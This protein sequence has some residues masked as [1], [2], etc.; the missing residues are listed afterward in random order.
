M[1]GL[2]FRP[3]SEKDLPFLHA[4][5]GTTRA[6]ELAMVPWSDQQKVEFIDMQFKAQ[7]A[8]YQEHFADA[9]F[10]I[11]VKASQDIGRLY[12][13]KRQTEFRIIDIALMPEQQNMGLGRALLED[14]ID[15]AKQVNLPVTIHVEKN[16]PAMRLYLR[17][18]FET[19]EDQGVYDL[20]RWHA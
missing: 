19:V 13:D 8:Y 7:H 15:Q 12:L 9:D 16:N 3:I 1:H 17:L 14:V 5:Y 20:M 11:I 6:A 4:L 10:A 2:S 18:G